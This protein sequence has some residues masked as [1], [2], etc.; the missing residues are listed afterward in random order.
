MSKVTT[1]SQLVE[2]RLGIAKDEPLPT[3]V[4]KDNLVAF[5][6]ECYYFNANDRVKVLDCLDLIS[7]DA[8]RAFARLFP[9]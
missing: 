7:P 2:T 9:L 1:P 6:H 3:K 4:I 8:K 5:L